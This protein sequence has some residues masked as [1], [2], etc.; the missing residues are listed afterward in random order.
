MAIAYQ[1]I[2]QSP[3]ATSTS[4]IITAPS[5]IQVGDLLVAIIAIR[6]TT[7]TVNSPASGFAVDI[8]ETG[9]SNA[10]LHILTKIAA[11]GDTSAG[12]FTFGLSGSQRNRGVMLRISGAKQSS[13]IGGSN[14]GFSNSNSTSVSIS[15]FTPSAADCIFVL[16]SMNLQGTANYS[17][18]AMATSDP[19]F[20]ERADIT[21]TDST[22]IHLGV[23]VSATRTQT[24]ATGNF[25]LTQGNETH[26]TIAVAYIPAPSGPASLKTWNGVATA[27]IKTIDGTAVASI[28][29]VDGIA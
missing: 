19:G 16:C 3:G 27:S 18:W 21:Y 28:K 17:N 26:S 20:T 23:A 4:C 9:Q 1:S 13:Y 10:G 2:G 29:T 5:G 14:K 6:S 11:S 24:T 8:S 15:G 12:S 22:N 7:I 25:T